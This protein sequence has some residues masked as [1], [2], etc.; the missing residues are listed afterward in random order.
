M[1]LGIERK[2]RWN[3][4]EGFGKESEWNFHRLSSTTEEISKGGDR[5]LSPTPRSFVRRFVRPGDK[6]EERRSL[7]CGGNQARVVV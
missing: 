3:K 1:N 4:R 7:T 5:L 6:F 2:G